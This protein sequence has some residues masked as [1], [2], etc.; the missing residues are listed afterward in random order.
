MKILYLITGLGGGGAERVVC[1]L[2][3]QMKL[4]GHDVKIAYLNG[5]EIIV[6]PQQK[7][8]ELIYLGLEN[9]LKILS[10]GKKYSQ[11]VRR[12]KPDVV[13]AHMVHANIFARLNRF[14]FK[15]PKLICTAHNSIEGGRVR[16]RLYEYT[17]FLSNLNTNVSKEATEIFIKKKAFNQ[18]AITV[19]NGIDLSKFNLPVICHG[20]K[21]NSEKIILAVGRLSVQKDYPNLLNAISLIKLDT[22]FKLL[23]AGEGEERDN[24][25]RLIQQLNLESKVELLG[26]RQDI[27]ELMAR[28]DLFVL[29]SAFEGFGLVVAEAM[30]CQTFVVAT[31]CGGVKEVMGSYGLLVPPKD[32]EA[33]A[34]AIYKA[35]SIPSEEQRL[36]NQK[37]LEYV[38][39]NFDLN[40]IMEKWIELYES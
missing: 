1:D 33:L 35:L 5:A 3:D 31:D 38:Q 13:H 9:P 34:Q 22:N 12:Y 39:Q 11:L 18:N 27:P 37:A 10:A 28:A 20:K 23:I 2:A 21:D 16:M 19:Y 40:K 7:G 15:I 25:C 17:N 8:I 24:I 30:A 36:N 14:F 26:R 29:S 6:H 4:R 32:P